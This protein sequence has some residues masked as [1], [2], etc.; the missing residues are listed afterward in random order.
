MPDFPFGTRG[1]YCHVWSM[2]CWWSNQGLPQ[3]FV[4][5]AFNCSTLEAEAGESLSVEG[6]SDLLA[7]F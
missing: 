6:Y 4:P 3:G 5:Q 2:P 7:K 1:M